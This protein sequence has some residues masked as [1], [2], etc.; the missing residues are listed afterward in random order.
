MALR[1]DAKN[2]NWKEAGRKK[3]R[4]NARVRT[5]SSVHDAY[6]RVPQIRGN[7][8]LLGV[9]IHLP[10]RCRNCTGRVSA[11]AMAVERL[12][13]VTRRNGA[14][15]ELGR[16]SPERPHVELDR[17]LGSRRSSSSFSLGPGW[18][19]PHTSILHSRQNQ[20]QRPELAKVDSHLARCCRSSP[21]R[22]FIFLWPFASTV[23][24]L[25]P[26]NF[27]YSPL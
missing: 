1:I 26:T 7:S 3:A 16:R 11:M 13:L 17:M 23:Q 2:A 4:Q 6:R 8:C 5:S 20:R 14:T 9:L 12:V 10:P 22:T 24:H 25:Q 15:S 19:F 21:S 18:H 27:W